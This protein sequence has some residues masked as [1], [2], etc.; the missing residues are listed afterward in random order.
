MKGYRYNADIFQFLFLFQTQSA[1]PY[2]IKAFEV[3]LIGE[4]MY[5]P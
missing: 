1:A 5:Q 3:I 4:G 2:V